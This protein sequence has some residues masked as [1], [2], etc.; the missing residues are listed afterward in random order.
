M[1]HKEQE[2]SATTDETNSPPTSAGKYKLGDEGYLLDYH[3]TRVPYPLYESLPVVEQFKADPKDI[4]IATFAKAVWMIMHDGDPASLLKGDN[5][6]GKVPHLEFALSGM[7]AEA[8]PAYWLNQQTPP[9]IFFTHLS[10]EALPES[11]RTKAKIIYVARNP[12]DVIVSTNYFSRSLTFTGCNHTMEE[13]VETFINNTCAH[14]PFFDN[15]AGY[16]RHLSEMR[17]L[18]FTTYEDMLQ[19][20]ESVVKDVA[21]FLGKQLDEAKI[22]SILQHCSLDKMKNN[23]LTNHSNL[24]N[25]GLMDFSVSPFMRKGI[26]GD[27]KDHFTPE[28]NQQVN[29]WIEREQ[30]RLRQDLQ[31]FCFRYD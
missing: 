20:L 23:K 22:A 14:A 7:P 11:I 31:G 4:C 6:D 1:S 5:L 26:V 16:R 27:W 8:M 12:K 21:R 28:L 2:K 10:F 17:N 18:F 30:R 13:T 29:E 19:D 3:G 25:A 15:I 9:R 24:H